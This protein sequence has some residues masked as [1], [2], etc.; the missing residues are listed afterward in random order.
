MDMQGE[1]RIPASRETVWE[2]LNDP[3]VLKEC[4][5]GCQ[6]LERT[7]DGDGFE[8]KVTAKV[9]PVK[10]TF[11]GSVKLENVNAPE[12]YTIVGEGKGGAAG[13]A[14]GSADVS[15]E[16][17]GDDTIL[18]YTVKAQVGGKLAQ[19]GARL[20]DSTANK[21]AKDFFDKFAE[22]AAQ[23]EGRTPPGAEAAPAAVEAKTEMPEEAPQ[24]EP[25]Q[26]P[27]P[28][29]RSEPS[30]A[31]RPEP[32]QDD[33]RAEATRAASEAA[34]AQH[35][36]RKAKLGPMRWILLLIAILFGLTLLFG[37]DAGLMPG[38]GEQ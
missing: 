3:E 10:A 28:A 8:A 7:E 16:Q 2:A 26:T 9:G 5:T 17:D 6:S 21:Y 33:I 24:A 23:R 27:E 37:G 32:T 12:S 4:I 15:L 22:I 34:R 29:P 31:E 19:L 30:E 13:F 35:E 25:E 38:G 36:A 18:R 14:K 1:Y 20:V 11:G